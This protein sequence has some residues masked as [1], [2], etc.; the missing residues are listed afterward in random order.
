MSTYK[1]AFTLIE[2]LVAIMVSSILIVI[3][4]S[5]FSVFR[6]TIAADQNAA[7]LSQNARVSLDRMSREIRQTPD[8]V[9]ELPASE[10]EFEDGHADDLTYRRYYVSGTLLKMDVNQY[11]FASSPTIRVKWNSTGSG[12]VAPVKQTISTQDIAELVQGFS[13]GG[14]KPITISITTTD[15]KQTVTF[16][17]HLYERNI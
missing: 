1:P 7:A 8:I 6:K 2:L 15:G 3:T 5:I 4:V 16:S 14:S 10:I 12:G 9:T 17:T 13:V 11:Y